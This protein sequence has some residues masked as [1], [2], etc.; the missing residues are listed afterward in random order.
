[1]RTMEPN[2]AGQ[3]P[4]TIMNRPKPTLDKAFIEQQR[5]RLTRLREQLLQA[6][7][8]AETEQAEIRSQSL[9]EAHEAEDDAQKLAMLEL[10]GATV[11][12]SIQRLTRIER[13]LQKIEE[14]TYGFSDADGAPIS[15]ERLEAVPEAIHSGRDE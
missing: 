5:H 13:A 6:K 14:G 2:A 3:T 15:R 7:R 4:G 11:Q 10:D 1:M 8:S 9:G 12:R